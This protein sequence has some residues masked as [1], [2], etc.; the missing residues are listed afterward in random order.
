[1]L[2]YHSSIQ[3]LADSDIKQDQE[4]QQEL[5]KITV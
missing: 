2:G 4:Y 3:K 1:M 5:S